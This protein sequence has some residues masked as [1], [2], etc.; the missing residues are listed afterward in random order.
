MFDALTDFIIKPSAPFAAGVILFGVVWGFFK[1]VESVLTDDTKLQIAVWL[2]GVE[3]GEKVQPWPNTFAKVFDRVFG[4]KHLSWRCFWRSILASL[5]VAAIAWLLA[6]PSSLG[7]LSS[8]TPGHSWSWFAFIGAALVVLFLGNLVPDYLS[9]LCTRRLLTV[10]RSLNSTTA[11]GAVTA[12]V[13][14][15][16]VQQ[17]S[18]TRPQ[19]RNLSS[20]GLNGPDAGAVE[21]QRGGH[22]CEWGGGEPCTVAR[23]DL[24]GH[25]LASNPH[26]GAIERKLHALA[27]AEKVP[28][29]NQSLALSL[30]TVPSPEFATKQ[31][32]RPKASR[33]LLRS[34]GS[35]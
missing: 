32:S 25:I 7:E 11:L 14:V 31:K 12:A 22:T 18:V 23:L 21:S 20:P 30:L 4:D 33:F 15:E 5:V 8:L 27:T 3:V 10:A 6:Y 28:C 19:L 29:N 13:C 16:G 2:V 9:L 34:R 35:C 17:G 24:H 1:G 26:A